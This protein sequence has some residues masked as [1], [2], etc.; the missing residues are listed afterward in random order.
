MNPPTY[1][2]LHDARV[3]LVDDVP[4]N[5]GVLDDV[6]SKA[7]AKIFIA[8]NGLTALTRAASVRPDLILLD[9]VMPGLSGFEVCRQL[10]DNPS[11]SDVAVLFLSALGETVDKVAGFSAGGVDYIQKPFQTE[12]VLARTNAHLSIRALQRNLHSQAAALQL[13]NEELERE[14]Q[15]RM[16]VER[17]M[18]RSLDRAVLVSTRT[19]AV[20]FCSDRATPLLQEYFP[21]TTP[22]CVP[23]AMM[24]GRDVAGLRYQRSAREEA[25]EVLWLMEAAPV[26]PTPS[27]LEPMGLT[28]REA[29]ILYWV[30]HGKTN[31]E[32]GLI[33]AVADTTV[34]KHVSNLLPKLGADNRLTAALL[35]MEVLGLGTL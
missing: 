26:S 16:A 34:K 10:K 5:L 18:R 11:T 21:Q 33:L 1:P 20:R 2:A 4:A 22:G 17:E 35:A 25:D 12:E 30:A 6:L 15:R 3:L 27:L 29:E 8:Q 9:V 32:I 14:M 19:G 31:S 24:A 7:G 28:P 13:Q 23:A